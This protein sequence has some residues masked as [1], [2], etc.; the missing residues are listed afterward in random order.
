MTP[1]V[2]DSVEVANQ[3]PFMNVPHDMHGVSTAEHDLAGNSS[4]TDKY[5]SYVY[6]A[7][8]LSTLVAR[9]TRTAASNIHTL[10]NIPRDAVNELT[11]DMSICYTDNTNSR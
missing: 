10:Q 5:P 2:P 7:S 8:R 3:L 1:H 4:T 11:G 6:T 9:G